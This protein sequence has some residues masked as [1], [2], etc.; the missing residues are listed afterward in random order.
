MSGRHYTSD[1]LRMIATMRDRALSV[2]RIAN[3]LGRTPDGI[4]C[5][6]R[7]RRWVNPT[8]SKVMSS[9][10]IFSSPEQR[11]FRE[12]VRS[13]AAWHTPSDIRDQWNKEAATKQWP[14]VNNERVIY[15]LRELGLQK[16]KSEYMQ[17]ESYRR[18]QSVAQ[19]TRRAKERE[20]KLRFLR[21]RR[22][23]LCAHEPDLP[24]RKCH[25]CHETWPLTREFFPNAGN[26]VNYFLKTCG[27]CYHSR[28][29]TAAQRRMQ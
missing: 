16:T 2:P 19:Q 7:T 10:R 4:Q 11:A 21:T 23:E 18:R 15:Y 5:A 3:Q 27:L 1:E 29:G 13:R 9:V 8:R 22:A 25:V 24:R 28:T 6:L 17:F 20:T 26:S 12:F 14:T